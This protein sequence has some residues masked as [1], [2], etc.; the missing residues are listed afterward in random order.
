MRPAVFFAVPRV[1]EKMYEAMQAVRASTPLPLRVVS[2]VL[3]KNMKE[4][5]LSTQY[6]EVGGW[7]GGWVGGWVGGCVGGWVRG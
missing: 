3:K 4:H 5:V 7:M 6:G 2:D 1:W